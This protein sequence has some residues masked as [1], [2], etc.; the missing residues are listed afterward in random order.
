MN[1]IES[2]NER[3]K[4]A[5]D[6]IK[7][8]VIMTNEILGPDKNPPYTLKSII[9]SN[10]K[11][12]FPLINNME[13]CFFEIELFKFI[14]EERGIEKDLFGRWGFR[15]SLYHNFNYHLMGLDYRIE[16]SRREAA[17]QNDSILNDLRQLG[18][19]DAVVIDLEFFEF[20]QWDKQFDI[21]RKINQIDFC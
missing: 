21:S 8:D 5:N 7:S 20:P 17:I 3:I 14:K 15:T 1:F 18:L 13:N 11:F 19:K 16:V 4:K 9:Y 10:E 6:L 2:I 12:N